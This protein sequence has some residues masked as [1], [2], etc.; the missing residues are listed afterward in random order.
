MQAVAED[1]GAVDGLGPGQ[2]VDADGVDVVLAE[3]QRLQVGPGEAERAE[4]T[5]DVV[6]G[7]GAGRGR[8]APGEVAVEP[9]EVARRVGERVDVDDGLAAEDC[10]SRPVS[11]L[12]RAL[13]LLAVGPDQGA[14]R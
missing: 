12:V 6:Q 1:R 7:D 2:V 4:V 8:G 14:F 9:A 11:A 13:D 5:R 3:P 10:G